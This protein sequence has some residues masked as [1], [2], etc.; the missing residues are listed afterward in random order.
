MFNDISTAQKEGC[1]TVL[2]AGDQRSL[3]WRKE[4]ESVAGI[5]P[6]AIITELSQLNEILG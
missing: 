6:D 5:V 1:K 3:R 2:F 4:D